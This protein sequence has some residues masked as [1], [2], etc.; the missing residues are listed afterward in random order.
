VARLLDWGIDARWLIASGLLIMAAGNYWMALMNLY[1]SPWQA[2]WPRVVTIIGLSLMFAPLN[3]AAFLYTPK[4]LRGAAVGLLALLRNEGG[5]FGVSMVQTIQE[6]RDQFH[7]ARVGEFLDLLNPEASSFLEQARAFFYLQTGDP[8]GSQ[9]LALQVLADLR[10]QQAASFAFFDVFWVAAVASL[11]LVFLV[12]LM[13][14]SVA[15]TNP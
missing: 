4:H 7:T 15:E 3:V 5:S 11:V 12:F 14:R 1:F 8:A 9:R 2:I 6:R 13:K 10:Q